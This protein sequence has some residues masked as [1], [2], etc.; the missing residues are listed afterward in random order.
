MR[1]PQL[2]A[3]LSLAACHSNDYGSVSSAVNTVDAATKPKPT[4]TITMRFEEARTNSL[5][6][7]PAETLTKCQIPKEVLKDLPIYEGEP[8]MVQCE[9]NTTITGEPPTSFTTK[10]YC[11]DGTDGWDTRVS[12]ACS[13]T[14]KLVPPKVTS[15]GNFYYGRKDVALTT[16]ACDAY[17]ARAVYICEKTGVAPDESQ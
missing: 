13:Q 15:T 8:V 16:K 5:L 9:L 3:I 17:F 7:W 6:T 1:G 10:L 4:S 14:V 2:F 11:D 12:M